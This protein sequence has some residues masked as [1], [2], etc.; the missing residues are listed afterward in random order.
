MCAG[1]KKLKML[2]QLFPKVWQKPAARFRWALSWPCGCG[3][4]FGTSRLSCWGQDGAGQSPVLPLRARGRG[5]KP[6]CP[7]DKM[8]LIFIFRGW[9][10]RALLHAVLN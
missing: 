6:G 9:L 10:G 4:S 7:S 8:Q 1:D 2:E 5:A 3:G